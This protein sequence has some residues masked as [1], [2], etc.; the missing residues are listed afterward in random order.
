MTAL[1]NIQKTWLDLTVDEGLVVDQSYTIQNIGS[2]QLY[3]YESVA[4]PANSDI[5]LF[6]NQG[7]SAIIKQ[8]TDKIF[9]RSS[10]DS[11]LLAINPAL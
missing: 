8:G 5:G 3:L 4:Q 6:L 1:V 9:V 2:Y 10:G 7:Q 11:G